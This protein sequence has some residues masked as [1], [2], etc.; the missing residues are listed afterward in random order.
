VSPMSSTFTQRIICREMIA[1]F[2]QLDKHAADRLGLPMCHPLSS[3]RR[4]ESSQ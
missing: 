3:E 4:A 2:K 1:S